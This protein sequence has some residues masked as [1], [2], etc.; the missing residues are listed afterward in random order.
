MCCRNWTG[1]AMHVHRTSGRDRFKSA[2]GFQS[3]KPLRFLYAVNSPSKGDR[4]LNMVR[5]L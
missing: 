3:A 5:V 1:E 4:L 2:F